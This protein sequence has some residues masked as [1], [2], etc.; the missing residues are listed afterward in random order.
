MKDKRAPYY[1][2]VIV[3]TCM[4]WYIHIYIYTYICMHISISLSLYLYIYI[5]THQRACKLFFQRWNPT[6]A[7]TRTP[8]RVVVFQR[9][10]KQPNTCARHPAASVPCSPLQTVRDSRDT[11][12]C[13]KNTPPEKNTGWKISFENTK[14]RAGLQFL[15]VGR[16]A[17]ARAKRSV[18]FTDTGIRLFGGTNVIQSILNRTTAKWSAML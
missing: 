7:Q 10:D 8:Y 18:F 12:V 16:M 14:S 2:Y 5:Y 9:W 13:E 11:G 17:K 1:S 6:T 3:I 15:L 4:L